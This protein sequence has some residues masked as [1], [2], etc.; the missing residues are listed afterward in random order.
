MLWKTS[1]I[2]IICLKRFNNSDVF[3]EYPE[4]LDFKNYNINFGTTKN[5]I[6][7]LQSFIVH[8]GFMDIG[9]YY[10]VCKNHLL[11]N[12]YKYNDDEITEYNN[13]YLKEN[14]YILFYK[15]L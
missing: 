15:R 4:Q 11:E 6:Y 14:P 3:I 5:N 1:D 9:H 8:K 13:H 12:W 2:I 10:S 7:T